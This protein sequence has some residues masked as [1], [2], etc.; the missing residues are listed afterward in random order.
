MSV[1]TTVKQE[2]FEFVLAVGNSIF[3]LDEDAP[4]FSGK[5]LG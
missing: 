1:E 2:N 4:K 3:F 5:L